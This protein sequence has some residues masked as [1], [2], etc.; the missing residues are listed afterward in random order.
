MPSTAGSWPGREADD[1]WDA[2]PV[3][4]KVGLWRWV[5]GQGPRPPSVPP[6]AD[7]Q[8]AIDVEP[9]R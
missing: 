6:P 4:R 3:E 2:L 8:L 9:R 7:D 1:W 5:T